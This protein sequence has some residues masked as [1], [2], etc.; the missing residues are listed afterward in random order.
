MIKNIVFDI[1][2]VLVKFDWKNYFESFGYSEEINERIA[3]ATVKDS[4]WNEIDR[5]IMSEEEILQGFIERDPEIENELR[6]VYK[7]FGKLLTQFG[8]AKGWI[9]DLQNKGFKVFCL[10]NM[11]HKAVRE[12]AEAMDFLP[13][14]DGYILSCDVQVIKPGKEIYSELFERYGLNPGECIFI[15]DLKANTEMAESLGMNTVTFADLK[16]AVAEMER[17]INDNGGFINTGSHSGLQRAA[18]LTTV[19]LIA[20]LAV[21][22]LAFS[23]ISSDWSQ[24]LFKICMGAL[25]V[26]PCLAWAFIWMIGK[27]SH[28]KTIADF[29]LFKE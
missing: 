15:D 2:N 11:S 10:S 18:A 9:K 14:L 23:I 26:L 21:A 8:Y 28:R 3:K 5:G 19:V 29:D 6:E 7:D 13:M 17:I 24:K 1:G 27:M 20:I 22:T 16:S 25:I 4:F 12:C